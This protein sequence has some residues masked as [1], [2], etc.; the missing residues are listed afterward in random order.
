MDATVRLLLILCRGELSTDEARR[1]LYL[2]EAPVDWNRFASLSCLHGV[3]GLVRRNLVALE[4]QDHVPANSWQR[5]QHAATQVA[6]DGM[7]QIDCL[8][9]A[10]TALRTAGISAIALKGCALASMLYGDPLVRPAADIDILVSVHEVSAAR[11]ALEAASMKVVSEERA[12]HQLVHGYHLTLVSSAG[13][14]VMLELHW[15]LAPRSLFPASIEELFQRSEP[16][17]VADVPTRRLSVEDTLLHLTLHM[18]KHRY[19]GLRWLA[20]IAQTL[21][22]HADRMDWTYIVIAA[23][24][25]GLGTSLFVALSLA[26]QAL[27]APSCPQ[28]VEQVRPSAVRRRL[29]KPLL[30]GETL[31]APLEMDD[32]RWTR[33]A[34]TEIWLL[35]RPEIMWRELR[36]RLLP[37]GDIRDRWQGNRAGKR[38]HWTANVQRLARRTATILTRR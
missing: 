35:D 9:R 16:F 7:L 2:M 33:L 22:L 3:V 36:F 30:T 34:A 15:D 18:R 19:V 1:A 14:P 8:A 25:M 21:R 38:A 28:I 10:L 4:V 29:L 13:P 11:T 17:A 5:I 23:E 24:R 37:P 20:D 6:F 31:I 26:E 12:T 27:G 32:P